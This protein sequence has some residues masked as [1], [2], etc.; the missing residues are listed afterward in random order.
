MFLEIT[1]VEGVIN[2]AIGGLEQDQSVRR[3]EHPEVA[4]QID[5]FIE[6]LKKL[7]TLEEPFQ[8]VIF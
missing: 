3:T 4:V 8:M 2:R 7:K 1:T 5:E 6:K